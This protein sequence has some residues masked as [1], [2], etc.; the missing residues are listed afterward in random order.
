MNISTPRWQW[1][2]GSKDGGKEHKATKAI[3]KALTYEGNIRL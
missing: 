1:V 2:L 3:A